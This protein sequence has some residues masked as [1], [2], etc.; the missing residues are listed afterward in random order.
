MCTR[1]IDGG[2]EEFE[3]DGAIEPAHEAELGGAFAGKVRS[4]YGCMSVKMIKKRSDGWRRGRLAKRLR[5][6]E[7]IYK[8]TIS[9]LW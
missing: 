9:D 7:E 6:G 5:H 4:L 2:S 1:S 3:F 8:N